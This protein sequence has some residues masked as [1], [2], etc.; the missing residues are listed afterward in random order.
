MSDQKQMKSPLRSAIDSLDPTVLARRPSEKWNTFA[1]DIRSQSE[2]DA[3][4][5]K[6]AGEVAAGLAKR[7][8]A[9]AT[10]T[11]KARYPDFTT[12]T[13]SHTLPVPTAVAGTLAA[14]ALDLVRSTEAFERSVR[15][16]G[17]GVSNLVPGGI[18]Q[19]A[20]FE[21]EGAPSGAQP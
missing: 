4:L 16:L 13:R 20:L 11:I 12:V 19:L 5:Q 17:V 3:I 2:I 21:G 8:L 1:E 14:C 15:L 18:E 9:A 10:I 7:E 6:M